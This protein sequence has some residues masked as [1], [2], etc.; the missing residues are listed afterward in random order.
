MAQTRTQQL[1]ALISQKHECLCRLRDIGLRQY[2]L[3]E[4]EDVETLLRL[5]A[6]KQRLIEGLQQIEKQLDP[7]RQDDPELRQWAS[8]AD[9]KACAEVAS[10]CESLLEEIVSQERRSEAELKQR[11]DRVAKQL[12][13]A[14]E[15]SVARHAYTGQSHRVSSG[16]DITS[17]G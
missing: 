8:P 17:G 14:Q 12:D 1:A 15:S 5:L 9:R 13:S 3:V 7:F 6:T 2:Q 4:E 10:R 16:F 11:R